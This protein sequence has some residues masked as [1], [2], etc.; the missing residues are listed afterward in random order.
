MI[1][2]QINENYEWLQYNE[3]LRVI[4]SKKDNMFNANSIITACQ[5]TKKIKHWNENK[6]T[7]ELFQFISKSVGI[8]S[9]Q[10]LLENRPNLP[11]N[12]KGIYVHKLLVNHVAIWASPTY[13]F[14][15]M[16]LLD[17]YFEKQRQEQKPRLV[18]KNRESDYKFLIWLE[19]LN[20]NP[21]KVKLHLVKRHKDYYRHV[22]PKEKNQ[23][24]FKDNMPIAMTPNRDIKD[25][26][27][28]NF[29]T[30]D[31]SIYSS[32]ITASKTCLD[33]LRRL[34]DEYISHYQE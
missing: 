9:D 16:K 21:E 4:H 10:K 17:E 13:S 1:V 32:V 18:P 22:K 27:R 26:I 28:K 11:N 23:W 24:Y 6:Q 15:I 31:V 8:P 19:E 2:E 3:H 7:K 29:G 20:D 12:L 14:F 5:S 34:I 33:K 25:I 30:N